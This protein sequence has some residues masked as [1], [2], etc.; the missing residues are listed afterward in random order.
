MQAYNAE[1]SKSDLFILYSEMDN[2]PLYITIATA[3]P[4]TVSR[5]QI[6]KYLI[7]AFKIVSFNHDAKVQNL[8]LLPTNGYKEFLS[9]TY[10]HLYNFRNGI[11][12]WEIMRNFAHQTIRS[13]WSKVI[14]TY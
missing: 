5:S 8:C 13:Q 12:A 14:A 4:P 1:F 2:P 6:A 11:L 10:W 7:T 3:N 9:K